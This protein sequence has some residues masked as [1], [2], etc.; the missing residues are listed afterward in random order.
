MH[1]RALLAAIG[2]GSATTVGAFSVYEPP[3][4]REVA[5]RNWTDN[6]E[7]LE[8]RIFTDGTEILN[9][10]YELAAEEHRQIL[11]DGTPAI[12][13]IQIDAR[14]ETDSE[15]VERTFSSGGDRCR[16]IGIFNNDSMSES[17]TEPTVKFNHFGPCP[18]DEAHPNRTA[19][20]VPRWTRPF[21]FL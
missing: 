13:T 18:P 10:A 19:C 16:W 1:C 21:R 12:R 20:D 7:T 17:E 14:L 8:V 11:C 2:L 15:W 5:V 9:E 3:I 4:L 6:T